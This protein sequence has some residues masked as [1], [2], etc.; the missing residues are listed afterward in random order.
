MTIGI[1]AY[2]TAAGSAV[3]AGLDAVEAVGAGEIRGF[4]VFRALAPDGTTIDAETQRGGCTALR[5]TLRDRGLLAVAEAAPVAALI[6][7][8]P[9][10]PEPLTRFL[11]AS[12]ARLVTGHPPAGA[13]GRRGGQ[14]GVSTC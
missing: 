12:R 14:G 8:G 9:D 13:E 6:S 11:P 3:L 7:S 2:G 4:G 1:A 5:A 10:R